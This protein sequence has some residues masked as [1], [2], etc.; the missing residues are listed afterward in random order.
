VTVVDV[1]RAG[2][3]VV[4]RQHDDAA[5]RRFTEAWLRAFDDEAVRRA[6][7]TGDDVGAGID[8]DGIE[9]RVV[10][11]F[12]MEQEHAGLGRDG[13]ANFVGER[14]AATS[15]EVLLGEED[16][17]VA[18]QLDQVGLAERGDV[19]DV[20]RED[21]PPRLRE[22]P[23]AEPGPPRFLEEAEHVE[24]DDDSLPQ[25]LSRWRVGATFR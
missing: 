25:T 10:V 12:A 18:Q 19:R 1:G 13:D 15:L 23:F 9:Q 14:E 7:A 20:P 6:L 8:Q 4:P 5:R 2:E 24:D 21:V 3:D 22:R 17:N 16:L 11:G